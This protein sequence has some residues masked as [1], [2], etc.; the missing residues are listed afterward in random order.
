MLSKLLTSV[1]LSAALPLVSGYA[2]TL[3]PDDLQCY[4]GPTRS[5][6]LVKIYEPDV[7]LH[8]GCKTIGETIAGNDHWLKTQDNC[9]VSDYY[10]HD[11]DCTIPHCS[12]KK[13]RRSGIPSNATFKLSDTDAASLEWAFGAI[14]NIPDDVLQAGDLATNKWFVDNGYKVAGGEVSTLGFW[15]TLR[16]AAAIVAFVGTNLV[17]ATK[18][19]KIKKYIEALGGFREAAELLLKASNWEERLRIGGGALVGLAAEILGIPMIV[20]NCT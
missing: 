5:D 17:S 20:N 10:I 18:L 11:K 1:A 14:L 15:D 9:Y 7:K 3:Q 2:I 12:S 6:P 13:T 16:C 8:F 4:S 19:F